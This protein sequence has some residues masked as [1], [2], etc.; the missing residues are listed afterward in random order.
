MLTTFKVSNDL[1]S[2]TVEEFVS[3][4]M[5]HEIKLEEDAPQRK[6]KFVAL[7]SKGNHEKVKALQVQEEFEES[8]DE[9]DE[10]SILYRRVN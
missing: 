7:K 3:S 2:A 5:S 4:L 8:F 6:G 1:N 9:E 10:L